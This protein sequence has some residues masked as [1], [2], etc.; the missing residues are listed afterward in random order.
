[1][2]SSPR[3]TEQLVAQLIKI[4]LSLCIAVVPWLPGIGANC[5]KNTVL[6]E[7]SITKEGNK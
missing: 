4:L 3:L 7:Y 5:V 6:N 2:S 1:M